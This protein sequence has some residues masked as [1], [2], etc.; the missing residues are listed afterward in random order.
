MIKSG[1]RYIILIMVCCSFVNAFE[2]SKPT[3]KNDLEILRGDLFGRV[4]ELTHVFEYE[5]MSDHDVTLLYHK[6]SMPPCLTPYQVLL[7]VKSDILD[8]AE[9]KQHT[10]GI[11]HFLMFHFP[12]AA[13]SRVSHKVSFKVLLLPVDYLEGKPEIEEFRLGDIEKKFLLPSI[14]N[15]SDALPIVRIANNLKAKAGKDIINRTKMAYAFPASYLKFVPQETKGA[16]AALQSGNG[17]CSEYSALMVSVC[18]AMGIPARQTGVFHIRKKS[19]RHIRPNHIAAEVYWGNLGWMPLDPNLG[20]GK[21]YGDY[22]FGKMGNSVILLKREGAWTWGNRLPR[23]G[24][25]NSKPKPTLKPE[26]MWMTNV[27]DEGPAKKLVE[28]YYS[29]DSNKLL[30]H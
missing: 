18:R 5:N 25:D 4:V 9:L 29:E 30:N 14:Y 1:V 21:L 27:L 15:E 20:G 17:D 23:G 2:Y 6:V 26:I 16:L 10:N 19:E 28:K 8:E 11:D 12:I 13:K 3:E 22:G 24:Y 7:D